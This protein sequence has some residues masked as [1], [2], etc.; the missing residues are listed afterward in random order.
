MKVIVSVCLGEEMNAV[1]QCFERMTLLLFHFFDIKKK[2]TQV[3]VKWTILLYSTAWPKWYNIHNEYLEE[4]HKSL[5]HFEHWG[6][7][8]DPDMLREEH[9]N[10]WQHLQICIFSFLNSERR[11]TDQHS[12][13]SHI[14][15][16]L[17]RWWMCPSVPLSKKVERKHLNLCTEQDVVRV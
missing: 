7:N 16:F 13:H 9:I 17:G 11:G 14:N 5:R 12:R 15:V 3:F 1:Y 10:K 8:S 4:K 2:V 6:T